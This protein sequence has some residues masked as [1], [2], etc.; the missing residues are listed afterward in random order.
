[1][2]ETTFQ[3][4]H[5]STHVKIATVWFLTSVYIGQVRIEV[6]IVTRDEGDDR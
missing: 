5:F 1:M 3:P 6:Q 2:S 4:P